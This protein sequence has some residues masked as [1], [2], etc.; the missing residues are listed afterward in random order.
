MAKH[1]NCCLCNRRCKTS[2]RR[3][4]SNKDLAK[5][6]QSILCRKI[7]SY[8]TICGACRINYQKKHNTAKSPDIV[9]LSQN[10]QN[11]SC[12]LDG[13]DPDYQP[14]PP[15]KNKF[16]SPKSIQLEI[17]STPRSHKYCIICRK[18]GNNRNHLIVI[19]EKARTQAFVE[20]GIFIDAKSRCCK[21][22]VFMS[23]FNNPSLSLLQTSKKS[24][25]YSRTDITE[26]TSNIR[27]MMKT[28]SH[29]NFDMPSLMTDDQYMDLIGMNQS[30]F[31]E[32]CAS[33][34]SLRNTATRSIRTC[35]AVFFMKLRTGLPNSILAVL[36][37]LKPFQV[38]RIVESARVSLMTD[39]VPLHLGFNHIS[40]D[41]FCA[42]HTTPIARQLFSTDNNQA[43]LVLDGTYL[44]IQKSS[45]YSFQRRSYSLHKHRPL[46]KPMVIVGSDGYILTVLGPYYADGKNNDA[47]ITKHM[48][49]RN[50]ENINEWMKDGDICIVDRGFRD[51]VEYLEERGYNVKMPFYL[52]KGKKQ[53]STEEANK[54]RLVTKIRWV[55]ESANGRIKQWRL[56]DKVI[57]NKLLPCI[58]EYVKIACSVINC[59]RPPLSKPSAS[60]DEVVQEMLHKASKGNELQEYL[61][62]ENLINRRSQFKS[63]SEEELDDFPR[64]SFDD[65]RGI[66]LG[67]YQLKQAPSYTKEHFNDDGNYELMVCKVSNEI[68]KVKMQSR[69]TN[70]STHTL[71]IHY[72]TNAP[73]PIK[74]WYCTCKAGARVV[75]CCAHISSVLWYLSNER[76]EQSQATVKKMNPTFLDAADMPITDESESDDSSD[77][78]MNIL[79]NES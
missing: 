48:F 78:E 30:Q 31:T 53:H 27:K 76:H 72:I 16:L 41:E 23:Y 24:D 61:E 46:I 45:D 38:R 4:V 59:F 15:T 68:I 44:Y 11:A 42:S 5:H 8:D 43:I 33:I 29:L 77:D 25:F 71:W 20:S 14:P 32:L 55:V 3:P 10:D 13:N 2:S 12:T 26:L 65:L 19:P 79:D 17:P 60:D 57:P 66:T 49:A 1:I 7:T 64:L 35:M 54:S 58:G 70:S 22:H 21:S 73:K 39:F 56:L 51:A 63:I 34:K 62:Q 37:R 40:H 52:K 75:G 74:G 69:H 6:L 28:M 67:V 9:I 18:I 36:F 47:A 50:Y